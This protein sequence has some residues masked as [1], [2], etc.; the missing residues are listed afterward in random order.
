M[1][2]IF[3][4]DIVPGKA[5]EFFDFMK[6]EGGPFWT[7]FDEVEK[8]EVFTKLGGSPLYEGHVHLKS[9]DEFQKIRMHPDW[10]KVSK[11]TSS[12]CL[13]MKRHF[14]M[15]EVVYADN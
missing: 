8:Y 7:Q 14:L 15:E 2:Y 9:F 13:N 4:F 3:E 1:I 5:D 11:K 6:K 12:Y 10:G